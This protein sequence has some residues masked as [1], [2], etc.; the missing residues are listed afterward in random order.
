MSLHAWPTVVGT[1]LAS[2][3]SILVA[4]NPTAERAKTGQDPRVHSILV[5]ETP[6]PWVVL[7]HRDKIQLAGPLSG[8]VPGLS[9]R[10]LKTVVPDLAAKKSWS[11]PHQHGVTARIKF[12]GG[13]RRIRDVYLDLPR[14]SLPVL[15]GRWGPSKQGLIDGRRGG[16]FWFE[17]SVGIQA[18]A[19]RRADGIRLTLTRYAEFS[20][21]FHG[22]NAGEA[23][24]VASLLGL[25]R[26]EVGLRAKRMIERKRTNGFVAFLAPPKYGTR[27]LSCK[28]TLSGERVH[29]IEF[30]LETL[31]WP[32]RRKRL[33][34]LIDQAWGPSRTSSTGTMHWRR[35]GV[36]LTMESRRPGV[37]RPPAPVLSF[38]LTQ[39]S[40]KPPEPPRAE[41]VPAP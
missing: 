8:V 25:T 7:L 11:M 18:I 15:R 10:Q 13:G 5:D 39:A 23:G 37:N 33:E 1:I 40:S 9:K 24:G 34:A 2:S 32:Q 27:N 16:E 21:I 17:P 20:T 3:L 38:T 31:G 26:A 22:P 29:R 36:D 14:D 30:K 19:E 6:P 12:D 28:M 35:N 4:C 41:A